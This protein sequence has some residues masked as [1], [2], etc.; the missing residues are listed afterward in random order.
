[1]SDQR[2]IKARYADW[3]TVKGRKVLQITLEVPLEQQEDVL[4]MLGAPMPDRDL[5]VAVARLT[6]S[7]NTDA[8]KGGPLA[9]KAAL[10]CQNGA[11][12]RWA[13]GQ[14]AAEGMDGIAVLDGDMA[15]DFIRERC[16]V[17]SRAML[18][19]SDDA[20]RFFRQMETDFDLWMRCAA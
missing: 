18:D 1:M 3:R 13:A 2:V 7:Q 15:A 17:E 12:R 20:T 10:L 6:E 14:L 8:F 4:S 11:F 19:H 9:K 16:G 5:W